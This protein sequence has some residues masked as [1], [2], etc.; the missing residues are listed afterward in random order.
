MP[1]YQYYCS[2][3]E[4]QHDVVK[5]ISQYDT[6]EKC[7][8]CDTN[9]DRQVPTKTGFVLKGTGWYRDGYSN[10]PK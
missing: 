1:I 6:E 10:K 7:P 2:L 8:V 3:C 5:S 9:M 4:Q